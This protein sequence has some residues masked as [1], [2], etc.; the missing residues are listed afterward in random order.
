MTMDDT[1][2]PT[3]E[4][5]Q[6]KRFNGIILKAVLVAISYTLNI[7]IEHKASNKRTEQNR[8]EQN[9]H[10]KDGFVLPSKMG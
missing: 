2:T 10:A 5:E 7:Y 1:L 8:P 6:H 4:N 3:F 9:Q